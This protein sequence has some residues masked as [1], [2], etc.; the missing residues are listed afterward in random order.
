MARL[1]VWIP[2]INSSTLLFFF[3][4]GDSWKLRDFSS[5]REQVIMSNQDSE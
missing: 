4:S 3:S 2:E 1:L 5:G